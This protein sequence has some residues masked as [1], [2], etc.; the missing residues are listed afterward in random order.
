MRGKLEEMEIRFYEIENSGKIPEL[1]RVKSSYEDR[2]R[3]YENQLAIERNKQMA[4]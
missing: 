3:E 2:F 1:E 4:L